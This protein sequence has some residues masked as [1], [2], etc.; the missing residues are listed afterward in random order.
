M[1]VPPQHI[2]VRRRAFLARLREVFQMQT[3]NV[4]VSDI[5]AKFGVNRK[6]IYA[7]TAS[8]EYS[9]ISGSVI[10]RQD[11]AISEALA[12]TLDSFYEAF[13]KR[14][15]KIL[16]VTDK[17]LESVEERVALDAAKWALQCIENHQ[18]PEM[19]YSDTPSDGPLKDDFSDD[20][21]PEESSSEEA[22]ALRIPADGDDSDPA[23]YN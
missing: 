10:A 2:A 3:A 5:A 12:M 20:P 14:L 18:N 6:T 23:F 11:K 19:D 17:C 21:K 22:D 4:S 7:W 15:D 16:L 8:V 13:S 9:Q 1:K